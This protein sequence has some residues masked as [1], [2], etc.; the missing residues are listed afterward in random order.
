MACAEEGPVEIGGEV[1]TITAAA[2]DE[3]AGGNSGWFKVGDKGADDGGDG[4]LV[5]MEEGD[6]G[7]DEQGVDEQGVDQQVAIP[8]EE[9]EEISIKKCQAMYK[10]P[11]LGFTKVPLKYQKS[12][13]GKCKKNKQKV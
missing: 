1:S 7:V 4:Q 10:V 8:I 3:G 5:L 2:D 6:Q 12:V 11:S 13:F 9:P